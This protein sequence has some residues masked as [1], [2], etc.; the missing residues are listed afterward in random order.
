ML[1]VH[2]PLLAG[3]SS[4]RLDRSGIGLMSV[5]VDEGGHD[6]HGLPTRWRSTHRSGA[7]RLVSRL[8]WRLNTADFLDGRETVEGAPVLPPCFDIISSVPDISEVRPKLTP[9]Q[10]E[11]W[12]TRVVRRML[13]LLPPNRVC[14]ECCHSG[15]RT[16]SF[17]PAWHRTGERPPR[18][19]RCVFASRSVQSSTKPLGASRAKAELG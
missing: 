12:A 11:A 16:P 13:E 9:P 18:A 19:E 5:T 15:T 10:Y 7:S 3:T 2:R 17:A 4:A 1:H 8:V 6:R 14:S